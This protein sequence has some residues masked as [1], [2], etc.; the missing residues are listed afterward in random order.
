MHAVVETRLLVHAWFK[1]WNRAD[2]QALRGLLQVPHV[3]LSGTRLSVDDTEAA[4]LR[5]P[6]FRAL[7]SV[8][9]WHS[10]TLDR[11]EANQRSPDKV[12]AA[13]ALSL[14][15]ADGHRYADG[16]VV[17]VTTRR[18]GRWG[19]Q[20][21]SGTLSPVPAPVEAGG[22]Q[23]AVAQARR[24]LEAWIEA[25]DRGDRA[26][27]SRLV[28]LPFVELRGPELVVHRAPP[29][30]PAPARPPAAGRSAVSRL[31]VRECARRKVSL[32]VDIDRFDPGGSP[33]GHDSLLAIV[34]ERG[35]RWALQVLSTFRQED[36]AG[37]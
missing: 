2:Q 24:V 7:A 32:E 8:Q 20:L 13:V 26:A 17:Y 23:E 33:T 28:H 1:A 11:L 14:L 31:R 35:G 16:Q 25:G 6:D 4:V 5:R 34:V 15:A 9:E 19:I 37:V 10:S 30:P 36:P 27:S 12:H 22:R 21:R 29:D 18:A 3:R